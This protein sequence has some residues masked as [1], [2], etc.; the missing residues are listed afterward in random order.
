[1]TINFDGRTVDPT[2]DFTFKYIFGTPAHSHLTLH[3]LN[4]LMRQLGRPQFRS[5][6]ILNPFRLAEFQ[7]EKEIVLDV[8]AQADDTHD[9]QVEMQIRVHAELPERMLDNWTR[10]Y[11]RQL[12]KG[13]DYSCHR[14][15]YAI[16]IINE[17]FPG[18]GP[19]LRC[20]SAKDEGGRLLSAD[21][22]ILLIDLAA[23]RAH[24]RTSADEGTIDIELKDWLELLGDR[25]SV[26][27]NAGHDPGLFSQ[28]LMEEVLDIMKTLS[29][30]DRAWMLNE[31]RRKA[32]MDR[33]VMERQAYR[34]GET[35]GKLEGK[36]E[37]KR[38]AA[39]NLKKLG[40]DIETICQATG[41][42]REVVEKL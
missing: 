12:K 6:R 29:K 15:V 25:R 13:E 42:D 24:L 23:W 36:I 8:F 4:S 20:F 5:L 39:A 18:G 19:W 1:M 30:S 14:P 17:R 22:N 9:V 11:A 26:D 31:S 41:L 32:I 10:L 37:G 27:L 35:E 16:W 33:Q 7:G 34:Q 2:N 38:E 21:Q 28:A 3:F 40:V